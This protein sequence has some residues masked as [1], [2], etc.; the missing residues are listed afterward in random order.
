MF[1]CSVFLY[2]GSN[3]PANL[4][5]RKRHSKAYNGMFNAVFLM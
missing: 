1:Y 3:A 4:K 2:L 5:Q